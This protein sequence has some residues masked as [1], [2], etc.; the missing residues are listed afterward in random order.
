MRLPVFITAKLAFA[1]LQEVDKI[2]EVVDNWK[3]MGFRRVDNRK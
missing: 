3:K 1:R 2:A